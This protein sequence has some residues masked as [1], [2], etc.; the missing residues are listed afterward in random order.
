MISSCFD[1]EGN[2]CLHLLTAVAA[3]AFGSRLRCDGFLHRERLI[4]WE[5]LSRWSCWKIFIVCHRS[6]PALCA[7]D[8]G[9]VGVVQA[10]AARHRAKLEPDAEVTLHQQLV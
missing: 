10:S 8:D 1:H 4:W 6:L 5:F 7:A 3:S 2:G 9:R